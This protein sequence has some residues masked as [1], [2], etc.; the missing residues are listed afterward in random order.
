MDFMKQKRIFNPEESNAKVIVIG[1]GSTGSFVSFVLAK[2][3]IEEIEVIDFDEIEEHN[4][5]NQY[6]RIEDV[7]KKKVEALGEIIKDFTGVEIVRT[8]KKIGRKY[9]F[10][11]DINTIIIN[12]VDNIK[13]R[14]RVIEILNGI[15]VKLID[16][17]FGGEG[18]S[19]HC[20]CTEDEEE[21]RRY[22]EGLKE[23][24]KETICGEK[25]IIYTINS[26]ASEVSSI[27]KKICKE[28]EVP[29]MIRRELKTYRFIEKKKKKKKK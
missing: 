15:P 22:K 18:Y 28:E 29:E 27:V 9:E 21:V 2:M 3:G 5:P 11:L 17:R 13:T 10:D 4:I 7:G 1:A 12:C 6:Y 26:L 14:K 25:G 8:N 16:T 24:V 19:I 23:K 20:V